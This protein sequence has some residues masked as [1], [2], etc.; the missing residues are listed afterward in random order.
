DGRL[1]GTRAPERAPLLQAAEDLTAANRGSAVADAQLLIADGDGRR[2]VGALP[3]LDRHVP[4]RHAG[5][6]D[7]GLRDELTAV[8]G[9]CGLRRVVAGTG[10]RQ[11]DE[12]ARG[13][14]TDNVHFTSRDPLRDA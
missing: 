6:L 12:C 8:A 5:E 10:E 4:G 11:H 7:G 9:G 14:D 1:V 13:R 2:V 3:P